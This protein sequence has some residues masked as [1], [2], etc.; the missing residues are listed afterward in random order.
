MK[1]LIIGLGSGRTA[2]MSLAYLFNEQ[3]YCVG[4][5]ESF[6]MPWDVDL[7]QLDR[8]MEFLDQQPAPLIVDVG[9]YWLNYVPLI[10]RRSPET[11]F[12]CIYRDKEEIVASFLRKTW[13]YNTFS[14]QGSPHI[15]QENE[16]HNKRIY[17]W[18]PHYDAPKK[19]AVRK[20]VDTYYALA[21]T[22]VDD[23]F[24]MFHIYDL[25]T[26]DGIKSILDFAGIPEEQQVIKVFHENK[27][28]L[29]GGGR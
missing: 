18:F 14:R 5:H 3:P 16:R 12:I 22:M 21:D 27:N 10:K 11:K 23:S 1:R 24:R 19:E 9:C 15:G 8:G 17:I 4:T 7:E 29:P 28:R 2:S 6:H 13:G 26:I 25:N 20:Y